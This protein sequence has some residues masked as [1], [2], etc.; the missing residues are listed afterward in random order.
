MTLGN[1][2]PWSKK[3]VPIKR[4]E[5]E[6]PIYSMQKEMNRM[7]EDFFKGFD[8]DSSS[9][10]LSP[11]CSTTEAGTTLTPRVDLSETDKDII[12]SMELPGLDENEIKV[13][14]SRDMLTV[15]GEKKQESK[16]NEKG[17]YRMERHYGSFSRSIPLPHEYNSEKVDASYKNGVLTVKLAKQNSKKQK[18]KKI[19]VKKG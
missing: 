2:I 14:L 4:E 19:S 1:L 9:F 11:I 16:E 13:N 5:Q 15:S 10:F 3:T 17:W 8:D 18:T 7:F 6:H 12:V